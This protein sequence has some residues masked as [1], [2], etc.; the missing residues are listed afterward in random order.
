VAYEWLTY[1]QARQQLAARLADPTNQFWTDAENGL[2][3]I[4]ALRTH[5]ALTFSSKATFTFTLAAASTPTWFSL[6]AMTGS[7]RLRTVTDTA[8]YT[9]MEYHL[10][11]PPTGG[12]WTG[13]T[14]FAIADLQN[15]LQRCQNEA[16]QQANTNQA[17]PSAIEAIPNATFIT[18]PDTFLDVARARFVS[19]DPVTAV[20]LMR[21][22]NTVLGDFQTGYLQTPPTLPQQ[23]NIASTPPLSL[24]VDIAPA[25]E[26]FYDLIALLS[27]NILDPPTPTLFNV[28]DDTVYALKWGALA[29]LLSRESEAT[30]LVRAKYAKQRYHD[31]LQVMGAQPWIMQGYINNVPASLVALTTQDYYRAEWD[32]GVPDYATIVMAGVDF[33]TVMPD[34]T[35]GISV[36]LQVL[37]NQPVPSADGDFIQC[38]RDVW[39]AILDY[40]QFIA[41]FKQGG[42]EFLSAMPL[43]QNF[44]AQAMKINGRL[45]KLGLYANVYDSEG[46][47]EVQ[48]QERF[49]TEKQ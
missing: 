17:N 11:E 48:V 8:L 23:Y 35:V 15:A 14:Q 24:Q 41:A 22:D 7:P 10:L 32:S 40:A 33:F 16:I 4:E 39:D 13:T 28:P 38:S 29:D 9:L 26:G 36:T 27:G 21:T 43:E 42:E 47:R 19:P 46:M 37:G 34:P 2:Y 1:L 5:N 44:W 12:S 31:L 20:T 3:I 30:D 45:E 18:L 25:I 6:G 49:E